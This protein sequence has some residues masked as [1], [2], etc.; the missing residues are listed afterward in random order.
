M[1]YKVLEVARVPCGD[2]GRREELIGEKRRGSN[3]LMQV[4]S[5]ERWEVQEETP[6]GIQLEARWPGIR[7]HL[8]APWSHIVIGT[9]AQN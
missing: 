1:V 6:R 7:S 5:A 9:F 2:R 3:T 8:A 4:H